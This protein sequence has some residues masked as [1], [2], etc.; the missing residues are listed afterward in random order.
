MDTNNY[1]YFV[2]LE[3]YRGRA[4]SGFRG[5]QN[6]DGEV[7]ELYMGQKDRNGN[8]IPRY[9][10]FS[11]TKRYLH[12]NKKE[13]DLNGKNVVE[14]LR[15]HNLC[16]DSKA[17][18]SSGTSPLFREMN[19][20]RD[21]EIAVNYKTLVI[22]AGNAA[23]ALEGESL[24]AAATLC[25]CFSESEST[26]RHRVMEYAG[27]EP[28]H[29]LEV[30]EAPDFSTRALVKALVNKGIVKREGTMLKWENVLVG[31][32]ENAAVAKLISDEDLF[33]ALSAKMTEL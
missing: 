21:A 6:E 17:N 3:G 4:S 19:E 13:K 1:A 33:N 23:L 11:R 7:M 8:F 18:T 22:K 30:I 27:T 9:F 16:E 31:T 25:G 10:K 28:Q 20:T 2:L 12:V 15:N 5:Y 32:D 26:Q 29:F 14:F 24:K